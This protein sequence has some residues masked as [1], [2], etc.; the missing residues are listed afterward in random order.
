MNG[1]EHA[2]PG[3][4]E[5]L[6]QL[7]QKDARIAGLQIEVANLLEE[8]TTLRIEVCQRSGTMVKHADTSLAFKIKAPTVETISETAH[9]KLLLNHTS[10]LVHTVSENKKEITQL[11]E[12]VDKLRSSRKEFEDETLVR[13]E[14]ILWRSTYVI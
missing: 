6:E 9:Y 8:V 11:N 14:I 2:S 13:V 10:Q 1:H 12:T 4:E 7:K 5:L 3:G